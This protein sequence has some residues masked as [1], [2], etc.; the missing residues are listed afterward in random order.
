MQRSRR[1]ALKLFGALGALTLVRCGGQ[2]V[3]G[4]S[5]VDGSTSSNDAATTGGATGDGS[6]TALTDSGVD[7]TTFAT[8]SGSFLSGKDYGNPYASG[9]GSTCTAFPAATAGPCHSNT[10]ERQDLTDGLI[11]LPT[12]FDLLVVDASCTPVAN[13]IVEVWFASPNGTYSEAAQAIDA[14]TGYSGSLSDLDVGFCTGN[15]ATALASN[16]LR[17]YQYTGTD[18]RVILDGIFPGWYSGRTTHVHFI[19]TAGG[20]QYVTS[21]L[22]FDESLTTTVYTQ[23]GS[24]K[25]HGNKD[26]SNASDMVVTQSLGGVSTMSYAQQSD[27]ALLC[28]QALTIA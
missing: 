18:G 16:W 22:I 8:G 27:G 14:G 24:Y 7:A 25:A 17:G 2:G 15:D 4:E 23:H 28:W 6:V 19:V 21:Q 10:F 13:A 12:R 3:V 9:L 11:G 1:Q 20:K 26:T 5:G